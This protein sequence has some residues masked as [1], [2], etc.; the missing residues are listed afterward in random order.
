MTLHRLGLRTIPQPER[1]Q[2]SNEYVPESMKD[3]S[4]LLPI[5][6]E[7]QKIRVNA[8]PVPLTGINGKWNRESC[9]PNTGIYL[10][11]DYWSNI[12]SGGSYGHTCYVAEELAKRTESFVSL[13]AHRYSL[14]DDL[15]IQ[16]TVIGS[17]SDYCGEGDIIQAPLFYYELLKRVIEHVQPAY[18]YE[19]YCLSNFTGAKLSQEFNIPYILEYN[20]S[21]P[22]MRRSFDQIPYIHEDYYFFLEDTV[23]RQAT[24]IIVVSDLVKEDLVNRGT[25]PAKILVNPN[26]VN[27]E[28][29][30]PAPPNE[31]K[32]L[33]R[34]LG[35]DDS[36]CVVGFIGTFG[37]WHGIG[38][39]ADALPQICQG[40]ETIRFLMIGDGNYKHL[41][42]DCITEHRLQDRVRCMGRIPQH[43][44]ARL[45]GACDIYV[46][47]HDSHMVD[48][49]F[50]GSPTKIFEYMAM[51][52]GVVASDLEQIGQ[53]LSPAIHPAD[54]NRSD[55]TV[56]NQ[57][58]VLCT[59]GDVNE[60]IDAVLF[61]ARRK[62]V[63]EALG[64]NARQAVIDRYTW[65]RHVENIIEFLLQRSQAL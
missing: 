39:L 18:I 46:S 19:R 2:F 30:K 40:D 45:L 58:S 38:V 15:E 31:K 8:S 64:H 43:E 61:L 34:E 56:T 55:L 33:R 41:V 49:R 21:E 6:A 47:P 16:Q 14:L 62:D 23:C 57:R 7:L 4:P 22:S 1:N 42:D 54:F 65:A 12:N 9:I 28:A 5:L 10:R 53:V 59:P 3:D 35:F 32:T 24:S 63:C 29:Y 51:D 37:G 50:F 20:G 17:A 25:D 52:G 26:G 11:M 44:G 60:F 27:S 13:M 36:H 48:S